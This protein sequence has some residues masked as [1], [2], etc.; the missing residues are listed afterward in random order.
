MDFFLKKKR[1]KALGDID[2]PITEE[3]LNQIQQQSPE[4]C[5]IQ[6]QW[7]IKTVSVSEEEGDRLTEEHRYQYMLL[8]K[9]L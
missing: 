1:R 9:L 4:L 3:M 7:P 6:T 5:I 8:D 2:Q